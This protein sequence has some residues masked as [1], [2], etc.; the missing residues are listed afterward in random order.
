MIRWTCVISGN[1][2][3]EVGK[4]RHAIKEPGG[5]GETLPIP[6]TTYCG[7]KVYEDDYAGYAY[8]HCKSCESAILRKERKT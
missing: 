2:N 7:R 1:K 3:F 4:I 5:W 8:N 6:A